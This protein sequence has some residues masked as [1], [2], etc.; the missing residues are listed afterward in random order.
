MRTDAD[1]AGIPAP[2]LLS[3]KENDT[4]SPSKTRKTLF[5]IGDSISIQYGRCLK[6]IVAGVFDSRPPDEVN[7]AAPDSESPVGVYAGDS[8][9]LVA[10][11]TAR[12]DELASYDLLLLNAGL[13]DLRTNPQTRAKQ[14]ELAAY[15][16]NLEAALQ[17]T[18]EIGVQPIWVS[19][20]PVDDDRHN[21]R[22]Q[23]FHRFNADVLEYNRVAADVMA[24]RDVP[25][26]DLY[27]FVRNLGN[28]VYA[29]AV[30]FTDRV[31]A[32]QAAFIAGWLCASA[33][34]A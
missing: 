4:L 31:Q 11:I 19:T 24:T 9:A 22:T 7:L 16:P 27:A 17:R 3:I 26:I 34:A 20:T 1:L 14:V 10:C 2:R 29:D 6:N 8:S 25:V 28:D 5:V 12:S 21:T 15:G 30:H 13:H 18:H 33:P 23:E 32:L